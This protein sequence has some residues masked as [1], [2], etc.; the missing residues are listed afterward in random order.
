MVPEQRV[1]RI[2][3]IGPD[4]VSGIGA[5]DQEIAA[6]YNQ[7][8]DEYAP[9]D[10]RSLSQVVVQ[11]Q[12]TANAIAQRAKGGATLAAAA[13]PAGPSAAVTALNDQSRTAYVGVAGD[14]AAAAVFAAPA[15]AV[16]GPVQSQF[17]WLVVKVDSVKNGGGKTLEQARADI[18]AKLNTDKRKAALEDLVDKVQTAL[19][20]GSNFEEAASAAKLQT[21]NT[22]LIS[23]TGVSRSDAAFKLPPELAPVL[24]TGFDIAPN[25]PP[26]VV[27]L[28][29]DAGYAMV[30]PGQVIPAS[31][32]PLE[33]IRDKVA[34]DWINEQALQRARTAAQQIADKATGNVSL[35]DAIKAIRVNLPAPRPISARRIQ[36]TDQQGNVSPALKILFGTGT[37]KSRMAPNPQGGGYFV[38]KV[39]KI[40]PGN[41]IAQPGLI[42][43]VTTQLNQ[44]ATQ[45]YAQEFLADLKREMKVKRNEGAIQ[46]FRARLLS[47]G[48]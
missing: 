12:V 39:D 11:D 20:Q 9:K 18:A 46:S 31:P 27:T 16:V 4:Q 10:M 28:A 30:S 13:A 44:A 5:S 15:G 19:D 24:K 29:A 33:T 17:G 3:R 6:Y 45:D 2:A 7:H 21:T 37:G 23:A 38:V 1:L 48:S 8:K 40:T 42:G 36:M 32:A 43:Q 34:T 41:A 35:A 47:S 22:P 25:D 14:K 26:E